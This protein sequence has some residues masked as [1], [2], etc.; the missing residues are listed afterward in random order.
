MKYFVQSQFNYCPLV[1]MFHNRTLNHKIN[2]LH[3][4]A[5]RIVYNDKNLTF[6]QLLDKDDSVTTHQRNLQKLAIEMYKVKNYLSPLL[7]QQ[8]F[9]EKVNH[10]DLRNK[11]VWESD[12]PKTVRYGTETIRNMGPKTW[13][14][15]PADIKESNSLLEFKRKIKKWEGNDCTCRI[16]KL[17]VFNLGFI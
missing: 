3:E 2:K 9:K 12:N 5:L 16:C 7:I 14:I 10:Y 1:W 6:K 8:L 4:R 15:V 17:Y 11:A 13:N